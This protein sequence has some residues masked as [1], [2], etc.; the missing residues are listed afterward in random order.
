MEQL[1]Q[2]IMVAMFAVVFMVG[3]DLI[4]PSTRMIVLLK[5]MGAPH[6]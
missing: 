3:K 1:V 2:T 5:Q 4:V 6:V